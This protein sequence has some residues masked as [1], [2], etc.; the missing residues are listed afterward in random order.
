MQ[1]TYYLYNESVIID[2]QTITWCPLIF[3]L[4]IES[5]NFKNDYNNSSNKDLAL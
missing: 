2:N 1:Q 3:V 4:W 5:T